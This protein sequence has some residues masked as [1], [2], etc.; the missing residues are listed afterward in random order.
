MMG[1][2]SLVLLAVRVSMIFQKTERGII[3]IS[4]QDMDCPQYIFHYKAVAEFLYD[5]LRFCIKLYVIYL[6]CFTTY[7]FRKPENKYFDVIKK[8]GT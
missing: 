2:I 5:F 6:L 3:Q 8:D 7:M 4:K 1:L